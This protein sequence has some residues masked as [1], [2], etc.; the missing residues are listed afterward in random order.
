M[1]LWFTL[2]DRRGKTYH[3]AIKELPASVPVVLKRES[4]E[5]FRDLKR[6]WRPRVVNP[7]PSG[8]RSS[9]FQSLVFR[10]WTLEVSPG[11]DLPPAK[12][13]TKLNKCVLRLLDHLL[14]FH[15]HHHHHRHQGLNPIFIC[16]FCHFW[17]RRWRSHEWW[18]LISGHF[19]GDLPTWRHVHILCFSYKKKL[20]KKRESHSDCF[21]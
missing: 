20:E 1:F 4:S 11:S 17:G 18:C 2:T 12:K 21:Y 16:C 3:D 7:Q 8:S 14:P 19:K 15:R 9:A 5:A 10:R 13:K 6:S